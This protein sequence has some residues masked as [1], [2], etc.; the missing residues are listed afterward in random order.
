MIKTAIDWLRSIND[1]ASCICDVVN[2]VVDVQVTNDTVDVN[3]LNEEPIETTDA[4]IIR[5]RECFSRLSGLVNTLNS[6]EAFNFAGNPNSFVANP[7]SVF[8]NDPGTV[9]CIIIRI[10]NPTGDEIP[11]NLTVQQFGQPAE[12]ISPIPQVAGFTNGVLTPGTYE[13]KFTLTTPLVDPNEV[14]I[15]GDGLG[16][17]YNV[18]L[19]ND[20]A[21]LDPIGQ[22]NGQNVYPMVQFLTGGTDR[23][24]RE[25]TVGGEVIITNGFGAEIQSLPNGVDPTP[26]ECECPPT[27]DDN[28][29]L[30][31][32]I[33]QGLTPILSDQDTESIDGYCYDQPGEAFPITALT[34]TLPD[35]T[36]Y[37][38]DDGQ[39]GL[40]TIFSSSGGVQWGQNTLL[41]VQ[42]SRPVDLRVGAIDDATGLNSVVQTW[43]TLNGVTT[44][45]VSN[46]DPISYV[47]GPVVAPITISSQ[48]AIYSGVGTHVLSATQD[49]GELIIP[50]ATEVTLQSV[51]TESLQ[52]TVVT[53]ALAGKAYA[54]FED[55]GHTLLE[56]RDRVTHEVVPSNLITECP[57]EELSIS[58]ECKEELANLINVK[59]NLTKERIRTSGSNTYVAPYRSISITAFSDDVVIDGQAV[60]QGFSEAIASNENEE[61]IQ[62]TAVTG[63][64]YFVTITR[65]A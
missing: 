54:V 62:N 31:D 22:V 12:V 11:F 39:G 5:T 42:F 23:F 35:G 37:S 25:T 61:Y 65:N 6:E 48:Q 28:Q 15:T 40:P 20:N 34:G 44:E 30:A 52:L 33:V 45:I 46:G 59:T 2:N 10:E 18:T 16:G 49:W 58:S 14:T 19:D 29:D 26:C 57:T 17:F 60:P 55:D 8:P 51:N 24:T 50:N 43:Q 38:I 47:P 53:P 41:T 1:R 9:E 4:N 63:S 56:Y 21:Q 36:T 27:G 32:R 7:F 64:D 13:Y 3:V